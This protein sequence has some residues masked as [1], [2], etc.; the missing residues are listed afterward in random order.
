MSHKSGKLW[1]EP[2]LFEKKLCEATNT[3]GFIFVTEPISPPPPPTQISWKYWQIS[4]IFL[5]I[6]HIRIKI[7][8]SLRGVMLVQLS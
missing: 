6:Y 8:I 4:R 5:Q 1:Q 7:Q 2:G 3:V